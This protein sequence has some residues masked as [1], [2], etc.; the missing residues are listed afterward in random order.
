MGTLIEHLPKELVGFGLTLF[1]SLLIGFERKEKRPVESERTFGGVRTFPLIALSGFLLVTSFPQSVLPYAL[2][3]AVVG[4][5]LAVSH[6]ASIQNKDIGMTTEVAAL[7][8]Y[9]I[10]GAAAVGLYW[11]SI[12]AGVIMVMLLQEKRLL[13]GL[14][15]SMPAHELTTMVRFL[16]LTCVILPVV[17]NQTFTAFEIN[18]FKV[19]LVVVAVS[20]VS[21]GSYLLQRRLGGRRGLVL[22]GVLGG[23][24]SSTVTTVVLSRRSKISGEA[25]TAI[26]GAVTAAT[27]V[28][29]LRLLILLALFSPELGAK[30]VIV[31]GSLALTSL[32]CGALLIRASSQ[33]AEAPEQPA[34]TRG[35]PLELTSAFAFAAIFLAVIVTTRIVAERFGSTGVLVLAGIMG[36]AHVD[37]FVLSLTQYVGH[38]LALDTAV[39]AVTIAAA[40]NN[41]MKGLY[42]V[43]FGAR[44]AG[45]LSAAILIALAVASLIL[46]ALIT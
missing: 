40:T 3:L 24:Y 19:W 1:L 28:M 7:V 20:S 42:A 4:L 13:E 27:G 8:T 32:A 45:R 33:P 30:L 23:A 25:P 18:P 5:L 22:A 11:I 2:G 9:G 15:T 36:A 26:A 31:F 37:P 43:I 38:G 41:V 10:G 14:A 44:A 46:L 17:P 21:Y 16:L 34:P 35:N 12:A 6:W 29:Y 39:L